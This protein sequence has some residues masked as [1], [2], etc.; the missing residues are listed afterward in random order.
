MDKNEM[1]IVSIKEISNQFFNGNT[2]EM[3]RFI[4]EQC[5]DLV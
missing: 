2:S 3:L 5:L 1:A 4:E